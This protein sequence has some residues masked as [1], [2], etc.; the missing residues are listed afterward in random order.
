[1]KFVER[2]ALRARGDGA[3]PSTYAKAAER[4]CRQF[5]L[6]LCAAVTAWFLLRSPSMI[7]FILSLAAI[8]DGMWAFNWAV[9][10]KLT[11]L[12]CSAED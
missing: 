8:Q 11:Q 7:T 5:Q 3:L 6:S 2:A 1:M 12:C 10:E 9:A 4:N